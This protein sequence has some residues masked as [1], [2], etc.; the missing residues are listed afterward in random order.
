MV[1]AILEGWRATY[2]NRQTVSFNINLS[3]PDLLKR[4]RR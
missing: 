4:P 3:K 2:L 1:M